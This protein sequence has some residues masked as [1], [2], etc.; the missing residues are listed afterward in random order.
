M[1]TR[2]QGIVK[3]ADSVSSEDEYPFVVL[4]YTQEDCRI[5]TFEL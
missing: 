4:K 3:R 2:F 1:N 5:L